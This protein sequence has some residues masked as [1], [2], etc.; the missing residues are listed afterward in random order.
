MGA[1]KE[2]GLAY[3]EKLR[4]NGKWGHMADKF[5]I[6][7]DGNHRVKAWMDLLNNMDT[8]EKDVPQVY[9]RVVKFDASEM[10]DMLV[11]LRTVN[12]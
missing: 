8:E 4:S 6:I 5:F 9:C 3:D 2:V 12:K 1:L 10:D 11:I 7:W